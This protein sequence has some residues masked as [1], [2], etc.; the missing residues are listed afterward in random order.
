MPQ[1]IRVGIIG[2]GWPGGAHARGYKEAG[3]FKVVAVADLIPARRKKLMEESGATREYADAIELVADKDLD[4]VSVCLPTFL[5][6][7]VTVAALKSGKH[8]LCEKP[9]AMDAKEAKKIEAAA[10][11]AKKVVLFG[12][13]RRFGGA[14]QASKQAIEKGYAGDA[15]HAR[16]S[17]MRTRGIPIGT[18]WFPDKARAGGGVLIDLGVHMLDL[19]WHLLGQPKPLSVFCSTH[20]RFGALVDPGLKFDVE[21]SGFALFRF[22]G[23]KTL[24][25]SASWSFNQPPSQQGT[26]CR[27][28]GDKGAVDVYTP[29]GAVI[30]RNFNEKGEAKPTELKPPKVTGHPA[31]MRHFKQCIEGKATPLTGVKEGVAL[32]QMIDAMYRSAES[33]KS[34]EVK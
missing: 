3:G 24:E 32:M 4:V 33:G 17:W 26:L 11:K 18:G 1:P 8:V 27:I 13:Q 21:D 34:A 16:S 30:Y 12:T 22:D 14:E 25:L 9:P 23:G 28:Y 2:G 10:T 6:A 29:Q 20:H 7:Q 19:A 15:Y 31:L 5:H